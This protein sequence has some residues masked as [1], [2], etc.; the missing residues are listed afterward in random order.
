MERGRRRERGGLGG[1]GGGGTVER[2]RCERER[3]GGY[4]WMGRQFD[5]SRSEWTWLMGLLQS[6]L[7]TNTASRSRKN[8]RETSKTNEEGLVPGELI[9][10]SIQRKER[11]GDFMF[12]N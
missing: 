6:F 3:G 9:N 10:D 1:V 8:T 5:N 11:F 7:L 4:F 2:I 12:Q